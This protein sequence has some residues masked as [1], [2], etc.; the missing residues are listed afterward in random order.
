MKKVFFAIMSLLPFVCLA[1]FDKYFEDASLRIDY[2]HSGRVGVEYFTIERFLHVPQWAGSKLNLVDTLGLGVHKVEMREKSSGKLLFS[3][4]YCSLMEEWLTMPEAK[5]SCGNFQE[6]MLMPFPKVD[7]E[8]VFYT[9]DERNE[10]KEI[11]RFDFDK[12]LLEYVQKEELI[13]AVSLHH[14]GESNRCLDVVIVPA[15]YSLQDKDKMY[16][17]LKT[18]SEHLFS[19]PPFSDAKDKINVWTVERFDS[20]SG[21]PGLK[22]SK[23]DFNDLGMHYNTFGSER[24]LMTEQL[25]NL[26]DEILGVAYDQIVILCNSDVY[27]GGGIYNFYAST[28]VNKENGFVLVH[29]FGHSFAGLADEYS[30]NDSDAGMVSSEIEPWERNITLMKDFSGKWGDMIE[31]DIPIPTPK[32]VEYENKVGVF[33]GAAYQ[34]KGMYRPYQDCLMRSDKPFC[35]VC[36]REIQRMIEYHCK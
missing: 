4:G 1:Q 16:A 33:E 7:V 25:W 2:S 24:Y 9:R 12:S 20:Q 5:N 6:V 10:Y 22:T 36:T 15:G 8:I 23:A 17:D 31:K 27:G 28:Y 3:K 11:S 13:S 35:P 18:C 34:T 21:I 32:T 14:A 30:S 19:K 29:E 26:H